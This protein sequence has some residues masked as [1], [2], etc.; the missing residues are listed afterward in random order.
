MTHLL[1]PND[2]GLASLDE[3]R[4]WMEAQQQATAL[5]KRTTPLNTQDKAFIE[6]D[7]HAY[8]LYDVKVLGSRYDVRIM[9]RTFMT[10]GSSTS[11]KTNIEELRSADT[12]GYR[13]LDGHY[14]GLP[15]LIDM[16]AIICALYEHKDI[17]DSVQHDI[18]DRMRLSL[19]HDLNEGI[20]TGTT[21]DYADFRHQIPQTC[22][23][24]HV[25]S[26]WQILHATF[27]NTDPKDGVEMALLGRKDH[28]EAFNW[29][30]NTRYIGLNKAI[31]TEAERRYTAMQ[32]VGDAFNI[33][34][35]LTKEERYPVRGVIFT[36]REDNT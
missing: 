19:S 23:V 26:T 18:V 27:N 25:S 29:L 22:E 30:T 16:T 24:Q 12:T 21:V 10:G 36:K 15:C 2:N 6:R 28:R 1:K 31:V 33:H 32:V 35:H 3:V 9:N 13:W 5:E 8:T 11:R 17:E 4:A 14:Y 20:L 7:D 34:F